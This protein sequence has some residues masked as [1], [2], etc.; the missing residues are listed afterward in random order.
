MPVKLPSPI[1]AAA[2]AVALAVALA[3]HA[4]AHHEVTTPNGGEALQV[5]AVH[6]VEWVVTIAHATQS[7]DVHYSRDGLAGPQARPPGGELPGWQQGISHG[8]HGARRGWRRVGH[9]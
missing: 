7:W 5:G 1:S 9:L 6:R 4:T 8:Q 3:G 2:L